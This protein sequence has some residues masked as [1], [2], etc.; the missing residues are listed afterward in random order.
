M[1][2]VKVKIN[3]PKPSLETVRSYRDF[4]RFMDRYR[5]YYSTDGIRHML[6]NDRKKLVYIVIII[7]FL[8]LLLFV[9]DITT[10]KNTDNGQAP[11]TEQTTE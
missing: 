10:S 7:L 4:D 5:K 2:Q 9:D 1:A 6:Y 8:M 11:S 3:A